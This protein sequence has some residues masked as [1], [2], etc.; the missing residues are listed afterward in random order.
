MTTSF[1]T[2]GSG[3][4][5]GALIRRLVG[6]GHTV[7]ALARSDSAAAKV[8]ELGTEAVRGD[9][10]DVE[11]LTAGATGAELAFH[12]AAWLSRDGGWADF[13]RGNVE[14]T[15]NVVEACRKAGVRRLVHVGTEAS[16]M[17]GQPLVNVD[18]T[19]P[20]RPDAKAPYPATKAAAE[21]VVIEAN[22]DDLETVSVRPRFVWGAGDTTLL[23]AL[24]G[25]VKAGKFAWIGGGTHLTATTHIDNTVEGLVLGATRGKPGEAY[26]VT[27]GDP[28]VFKEFVTEMLGTQG[29]TPSDRA[30]PLWLAKLIAEVG[31]RTYQLLGRSGLPPLDY[32]NV[33]ASGQ[34][35]TINIAKARA[36]LGYSPVRG[37]EDGMAGLRG[38][39]VN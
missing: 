36:E 15:R 8:S 11:A 9:L 30:V 23:P 4:I 12:S 29:V 33:W 21:R 1:V 32:F 10:S 34:E 22:G 35:C 26:F 20:L 25:M 13:R 2:G 38:G 3:F 39:A 17:A 19:A 27:D 7:K 6:D 16:V 31:Q 18:E 5:G 14:G 28:V 24:V 37:R